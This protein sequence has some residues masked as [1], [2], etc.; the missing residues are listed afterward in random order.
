MREK[1]GR[2]KLLDGQRGSTGGDCRSSSEVK[3]LFILS[4]AN[5]ASFLPS[6]LPT[7]NRQE[8]GYRLNVRQGERQ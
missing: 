8:P 3:R 6:F 2:R 5:N 4:L 1:G 7:E